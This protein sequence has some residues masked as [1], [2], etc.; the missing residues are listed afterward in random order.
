MTLRYLLPQ[1]PLAESDTRPHARDSLL[2]N[3]IPSLHTLDRCT[4]EQPSDYGRLLDSA[5]S[6]GR[7]W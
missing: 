4:T 3:W 5:A 6:I 1:E 7:L 2:E